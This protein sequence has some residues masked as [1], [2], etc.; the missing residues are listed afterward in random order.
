VGPGFHLRALCFQSRYSTA[1]VTPPGLFCSG[2]FV[3]GERDNHY[4]METT[5]SGY[6][7]DGISRTFCPSWPWTVILQFSTSQVNRI[8]GVNYHF[9]NFLLLTG[10]MG[11]LWEVL[12]F[13]RLTVRGLSAHSEHDNYSDEWLHVCVTDWV[14][15]VSNGRVFKMFL[16]IFF[17]Y[18]ID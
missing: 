4:T 1:W 2:Y 12:S 18:M 7:G 17:Q 6:F 11:V 16:V 8:I 14:I 10:S 5:C 9:Y 15:P 3:W 13:A